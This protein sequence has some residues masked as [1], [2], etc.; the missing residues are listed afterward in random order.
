MKDVQSEKDYRNVPLKKVGINSLR[1]PIIIKEKDGGIQNTI[2]DMALSVDLPADVKGTHMSRFV[3]LVND[4]KEISPKEIDK[5]L[6]ALKEKLHA[7]TAHIR[8]DFDYFIKK[9]S[10]VTGIISPYDVKCSFDAE[11]GEDFKFIMEVAVPVSTLCPC[12]KEISDFGAHNQRARVSIKIVSK[13]LIWIEDV[14]KI[15]EDSASSP[16]F[17]LLKRKDEKY[18]TEMAYLNPRFVE[19]VVREAAIRLDEIKDITYYRVY[20]ESMESIHNHNAFAC[21]EKGEII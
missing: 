14:V 9:P 6:D 21:A 16:V 17:S 13:K 8:I 15:A 1:W 2:A 5:A 12:S 18:V 7:K 11:K 20:A 3:E 4:L 19:D 10:P